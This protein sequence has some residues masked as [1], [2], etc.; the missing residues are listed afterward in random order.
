MKNTHKPIK[1]L[2]LM[3]VAL[4]ALSAAAADEPIRFTT[5]KS[6]VVDD[7]MTAAAAGEPWRAQAPLPRVPEPRS[8]P[9]AAPTPALS[10]P[11][12]TDLAL[13]NNP[14]TREAWSAARAEAAALGIAHSL[15][16]PQIDGLVNLTHSKSISSSGTAVPAQ[17]RYGPALSLGYLLFDFGAR[18]GRVEAA[19]YRL[20]AAN[21]LQNRALQDVVLLVE[22]T[23]YQVLGLDQLVA[24]NREA[25]KSVEASLD[26]ANTRRQ[27]GLA[28]VGDV[29]RAETA[30]G[31]ARLT[32]RRN[33]GELAKA[34]G[35]LAVAVGVAV[36]TPFTLK[37]WP[38]VPPV[39]EM[40]ESVDIVL[41]EA[42]ATRPDLVAA[43]AQARAAQAGVG[44]AKAAGL[45]TLELTT[46]IGRTA[47]AG[48]SPAS[49]SYSVGLSLRIPLFSGFSRTYSV[50]QAQALADQAAAARDRLFR[51]TE[52]EV[53]QA[54]FDLNAAASAVDTSISV[55]KSADQSAEV[56]L[57]RYK[58][59]VGS[60]LDLL[61]AQADQANARVQTIQTQL[62]WYTGLARLAH[63]RGALP[64]TRDR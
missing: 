17:T 58:S 28:T 8:T 46:N 53:W 14:A 34:R 4:S 29:F 13:S 33:E 39:T 7:G 57:G 52:L 45:P 54:Y 60:L 62:D 47:F 36:N 30:V 27:A 63:A 31:Q 43:E 9:I 38:E 64:L 2:L 49:N 20:L 24:A 35:R 41:D 23:Y 22:Q 18:A 40:R 50:R 61:T 56:A 48:D 3:L 5:E 32:L 15:Y 25:L 16:F 12:L 37:H 10:L 26:A 44:A 6:P 55:L 1:H 11:Q 19:R 59:G 21:L 51:Q 42:R